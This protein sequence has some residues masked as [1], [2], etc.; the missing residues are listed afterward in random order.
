MRIDVARQS[1]PWLH[2]VR[3]EIVLNFPTVYVTAELHTVHYFPT[4]HLNN[5][6]ISVNVSFKPSSIEHGRRLIH[7]ILCMIQIY[8][9]YGA[10]R[11]SAIV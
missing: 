2:H 1:F 9:N 11:S 3:N 10:I 6:S 8:E 5:I 4:M 7:Y